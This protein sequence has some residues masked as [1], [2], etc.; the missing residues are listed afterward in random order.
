[1]EFTFTC[2]I[3]FFTQP[4]QYLYYINKEIFVPDILFDIGVYFAGILYGIV[5]LKQVRQ[6]RQLFQS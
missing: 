6:G 1:M 4:E 3:Y 2:G 5:N